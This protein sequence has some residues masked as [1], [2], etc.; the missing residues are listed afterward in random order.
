M[1][2]SD[3]RGRGRGRPPPGTARG[4]PNTRRGTRGGSS[5][6]RGRGGAPA[7]L[8]RMTETATRPM[9]PAP[10]LSLSDRMEQD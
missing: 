5:S 4:G 8:F 9:R 2:E 3:D 6:G 1:N 7:L 10:A